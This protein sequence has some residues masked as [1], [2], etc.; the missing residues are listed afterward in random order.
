M[1]NEIAENLQTVQDSPG[2]RRLE[3]YELLPTLYRDGE[4]R[5]DNDFRYGQGT[6]GQ[7]SSRPRARSALKY[8]RD[9]IETVL[10]DAGMRPKP[11]VKIDWSNCTVV[12][13][14][15]THREFQQV[16]D[17]RYLD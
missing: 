7:G 16:I 6:F 8:I 11:I 10:R 15:Q 3:E 14:R 5:I 17:S 9:D 13:S 1:K 12:L 4:V 2:L